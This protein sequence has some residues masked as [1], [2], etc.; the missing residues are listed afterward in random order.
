MKTPRSNATHLLIAAG[1]MTSPLLNAATLDID[2]D[3]DVVSQL[4]LDALYTPGSVIYDELYSGIG[5]VDHD[6]RGR[7]GDHLWL[8]ED[9]YYKLTLTDY[10]D[11]ELLDN[12]ATM[13][14]SADEKYTVLRD[15]GE[16]I[17]EANSGWVFIG[18]RFLDE[19]F[20]GGSYGIQL[21]YLGSN[22]TPVPLPGALWLFGSG[23][24][25]LGLMRRR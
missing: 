20:S 22:I 11:P 24:A 14:R 5:D 17:F 16:I 23:L 18:S 2:P 9:G 15:T 10:S 12:L 13:I 8:E 19:N 7:Y 6:G 1:L 25:A 4:D 3:Q 21:E